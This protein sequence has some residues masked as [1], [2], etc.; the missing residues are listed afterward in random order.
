MTS[1]QTQTTDLSLDTN[2]I[3]SAG[4]E[5]SFDY[6]KAQQGVRLLLESIGENP[7]EGTLTE[8]WN[9]RVPEALKTLSEGY[10]EEGKPDLKTFHAD[11]D[12][13][14]VKTGLPL[15]SLC[16]HHLL[17]Y[18]GTAHVSYRPDKEVVGLSK[19]TRYVRW[20]SRRLT[21]QEQLTNDIAKGLAED[22][23]AEVVMVEISAT[24][25]CEAMRGIETQSET[26][27]IAI[28]GGPT[29]EERQRF[30]DAIN[31]TEKTQ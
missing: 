10:R 30:R 9:R 29:D 25:L 4:D 12:D 17:P 3:Q 7:H 16:E 18:T 14:V 24:H 5:V 8:T 6:E 27:T 21:V 22:L 1:D 28:H 19:L 13:L 23:G 15:Y 20:Q 26:R 2:E 31:R 11:N